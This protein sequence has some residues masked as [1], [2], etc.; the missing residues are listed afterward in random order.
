MRSG[1]G[2]PTRTALEKHVAMQVPKIPVKSSLMLG[3]FKCFWAV[4]YTRYTSDDRNMTG[5]EKIKVVKA[6]R[7]VTVSSDGHM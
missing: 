1:S 4:E 6:T 5:A 2:N 7:I 3:S